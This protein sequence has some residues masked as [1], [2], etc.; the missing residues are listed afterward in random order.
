M[1]LLTE[2][3]LWEKSIEMQVKWWDISEKWWKWRGLFY[4]ARREIEEKGFAREKLMREIGGSPWGGSLPDTHKKHPKTSIQISPTT[5]KKEIRTHLFKLVL[6][7]S[8]VILDFKLC[9]FWVLICSPGSVVS[10]LDLGKKKEEKMALSMNRDSSS[11]EIDNSKYVRYTPEQVE[12]LER[13]YMEC[14]KPSSLK[15]QQLIRECPLL[16]NIEPKQIKVWFQNR[17]YSLLVF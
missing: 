17:R 9:P 6:C 4:L 13:V 2:K 15:R 11:R 8:L 3:S 5:A 1:Y 14:P 10:C 7:F 12:A 16:C